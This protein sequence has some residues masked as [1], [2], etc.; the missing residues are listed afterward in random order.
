MCSQIHVTLNSNQR[1]C[2]RKKAKLFFTKRQPVVQ[3]Y[4][5][6][7]VIHRYLRSCSELQ[8]LRKI[9]Q[10]K[11]NEKSMFE[12]SFDQKVCLPEK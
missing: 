11:S 1:L 10:Q 12:G 3:H 4:F 7:N 9:C 8:A 2:K 5:A 6:K